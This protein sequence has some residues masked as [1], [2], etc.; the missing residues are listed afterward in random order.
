MNAGN[1]A[2]KVDWP[3][4]PCERNACE[5]PDGCTRGA[6]HRVAVPGWG[7]LRLCRRHA[8]EIWTG[9]RPAGKPPAEPVALMMARAA[10]A[11]GKRLRFDA[12]T[13]EWIREEA[14]L[15]AAAWDSTKEKV[16][17][18][19]A[20]A[21]PSARER[22]HAEAGMKPAWSRWRSGINTARP[23]WSWRA[24]RW[25]RLRRRGKPRDLMPWTQRE[26]QLKM[27]E[28]DAARERERALKVWEDALKVLEREGALKVQEEK[29]ARA[30]DNHEERERFLNV[31]ARSLDK[32]QD[33]LG[34]KILLIWGVALLLGAVFH[35]RMERAED[36]A[37]C[38]EDVV[39][40]GG[41]EYQESG[42]T[43]REWCREQRAMD[44]EYEAAMR[45]EYRG[46]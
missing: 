46:Y 7:T 25:R 39:R 31:W 43:L 20:Q 45:Y 24:P 34:W 35:E 29:L 33:S 26:F 30:R 5:W 37:N 4:D 13:R 21:A 3:P 23:R 14:A 42:L 9:G 36:Y 6:V 11:A 19:P 12:V 38:F 8:V 16:T 2:Y 27:R 17:A 10:L 1:L 32:Q 28:H 18:L 22:K 40:F 41:W 44:A 15:S